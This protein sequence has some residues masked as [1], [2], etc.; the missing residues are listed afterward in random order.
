MRLHVALDL[1]LISLDMRVHFPGLELHF[2]MVRLSLP[3]NTSSVTLITITAVNQ[4]R[5]ALHSIL[6][7]LT[8]AF[9]CPPT[10]FR[11]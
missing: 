11:V 9:G 3:L 1:K 8:A 4:L 5:V 2:R 7:L 6:V 10:L